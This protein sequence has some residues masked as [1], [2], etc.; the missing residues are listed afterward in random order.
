MRGCGG[1]RYIFSPAASHIFLLLFIE[2]VESDGSA[3]SG[4]T[5][6]ELKK[7]FEDVS[8]APPTNTF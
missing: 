3:S 7:Y 4:D 6:I 5:L 1:C 2:S 8:S